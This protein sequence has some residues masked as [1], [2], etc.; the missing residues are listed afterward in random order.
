MM[1]NPCIVHPH[2]KPTIVLDEMIC[3]G[4]GLRGMAERTAR[5]GGRLAV[6]SR[7]GGGTRVRVEVPR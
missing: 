4:F 2:I 6:E 5:L 7:P 1:G 3:D